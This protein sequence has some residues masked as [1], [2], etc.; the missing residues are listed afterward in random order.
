[1]KIVGWLGAAI[2]AFCVATV[3]SLG[4]LGG[5]LW[6]KGALTGDRYLAILAAVYGIPP[7]GSEKK[8]EGEQE[9]NPEQPSLEAVVERRALASLDL[10]LRESALDKSLQDLRN[11]EAQIKTE[12]DRLD[13]WKQSFDSRIASLETGRTDQAIVELQ[14]AIEAMQPK[15]AKE[16]LMQI[17]TT[18]PKSADDQPLYDV[19]NLLKNMPL[20]KR[21][22]IFAEFKAPEETEKL[23]EILRVI[24][25]GS[26]ETELLRD[27]RKQMQQTLN[28]K[29]TNTPA[30]TP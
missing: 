15:Q 27:T 2:V 6:M 28:P 26:P 25:L 7:D 22:K 8:K 12:R 23:S 10:D 18:P 29:K 30:G 19:V 24:R 17:L 4:V 9:K 11:L 1:M 13:L 5:M 16:Q 14:Q 21:K 20:D 3:I